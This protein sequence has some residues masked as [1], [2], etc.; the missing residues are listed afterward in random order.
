MIVLLFFELSKHKR[1]RIHAEFAVMSSLR[2][3]RGNMAAAIKYARF[4]VQKLRDSF[5]TCRGGTK[6][7]LPAILEK[8]RSL[9]SISRAAGVK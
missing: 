8:Y 1:L 3:C 5:K 6:W 2:A 7:A 9:A 4:S